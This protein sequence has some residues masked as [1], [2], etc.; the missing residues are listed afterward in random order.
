MQVQ[1]E[2]PRLHCVEAWTT[3]LQVR[4]MHEHVC[5]H[6][7]MHRKLTSGANKHGI[8]WSGKGKG[9][10]ETTGITEMPPNWLHLD[11]AL[12]ASDVTT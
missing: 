5:K 6:V 9:M 1:I 11:K 12:Q 7:K 4:L 2:C 10:H 8:T 3:H